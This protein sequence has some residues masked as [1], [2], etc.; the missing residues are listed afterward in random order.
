M[1]DLPIAFRL[2]IAWSRNHHS[3]IA[4]SSKLPHLSSNP[5][6]SGHDTVCRVTDSSRQSMASAKVRKSL[7]DGLDTSRIDL[8]EHVQQLS[9]GSLRNQGDADVAGRPGTCT[10][11]GEASIVDW[12]RLESVSARPLTWEDLALTG[13]QGMVGG[14]GGPVGGFGGAHARPT[15]A[16][17]SRHD[18]VDRGAIAKHEKSFLLKLETCIEA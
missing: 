14:I 5:L 9:I 18:K 12:W 7:N 10:P 17:L 2:D 6:T 8:V 4:R 13:T 3:A 11:H 16:K 15:E 1:S